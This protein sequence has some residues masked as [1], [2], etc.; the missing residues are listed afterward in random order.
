MKKLISVLLSI[1]LVTSLFAGCHNSE[2]A[3]DFIY[4]FSANVRSYDPQVAS[5]RDEF[6]IIENTF[7]GLIRIDDDGNIKNGMAESYTISSDGLT[8]TFKLKQ[9]M[10]WDINP[11]KRDD[12]TYRDER[13][14]ML[15]RDFNPDITAND[16]VFALKRACYPGTDAPLF[17][18]ISAIKNA[19]AIHQ[20]KMGLDALGVVAKDDYTL[21]ISLSKKDDEFLK[22][23]TTAIAM[24]CNE[25]F[26]NETNGRYG[27]DT[28]YTL[29]NGQ[30]YLKSILESSYLLKKNTYYQGEFPA[31]A[32]ELTL[33]IVDNEDKAKTVELLEKG[34][35][36]SVFLNGFDT[37]RVKSS[38]GITYTPYNDTTWAFVLNTN[39]EVLQSKTIRSAFYYG[40][41]RL[42]D[43]GKEYLTNATN[44][45]P[46]ACMVG[47]TPINEAIGNTTSSQDNQKSVELWKKG[48]EVIDKE[49]IKLTIKTTPEMEEYVKRMLQGIQSGIGGVVR[50][51]KG[52]PIDFTIKL[53]VKEENELKI[54][55]LKRDY[56]IVF[57]PFRSETNSALSYLKTFSDNN[58][59]SF[60]TTALD[61][62][63]RKAEGNSNP[64][65]IKNAETAIIREFS[66]IPMLY[67]TSYYAS[68]NGVSNIS[69]HVGTGRVSFVYATRGK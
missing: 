39:N 8:Y 41:T 20:G 17:S 25:E 33:K 65:Y 34:Y 63:L 53:E 12:G 38:Q 22:A 23:L 13:L 43:T 5:T 29:F 52:E 60:N 69:F 16:F 10:K 40:F 46:S 55:M 66:I 30:F 21:E 50:N 42:E 68:A 26:F 2:K 28:K 49:S 62:E 37:D 24:P 19:I 4:P 67:E 64:Q 11:D 61:S 15:G 9:G 1:I 54:D 31:P 32:T 47:G 36:D 6:L 59:S 44:L 56:D 18:S 27:L 7:E 45:T 51:K 58:P 3:I 35:Y 14:E 48:L 57:Y